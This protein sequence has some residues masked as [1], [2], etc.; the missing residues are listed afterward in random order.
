MGSAS[1]DMNS[2]ILGRQQT[3]CLLD[4]GGA[5]KEHTIDTSTLGIKLLD[6][7]VKQGRNICRILLATID[8]MVRTC[9]AFETN[10]NVKSGESKE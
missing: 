7:R 3:S 10:N 8:E 2:R 1:L 4:V 9:G 5:V 6:P